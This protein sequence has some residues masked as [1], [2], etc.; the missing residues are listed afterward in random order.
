M[1][2]DPGNSLAALPNGGHGIEHEG[3][4]VRVLEHGVSAPWFVSGPMGVGPAAASCVGCGS[5]VLCF[6]GGMRWRGVLSWLD[7]WG[8]FVMFVAGVLLGGL[9][10]VP[11]AFTDPSGWHWFLFGLWVFVVVGAG[12][13]CASRFRKRG[14]NQ[15]RGV[16]AAEDVPVV[17]V[18]SAVAVSSDRVS[19]VRALREQH[20]GLGLKAAVDLVDGV[21]SRNSH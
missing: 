7:V 2:A 11:D 9:V 12:W 15:V 8:P 4:A 5:C 6:A 17:D 14:G 19:A 13:E 18:E 21:L 16:V 20:P 3:I 10:Y 1:R